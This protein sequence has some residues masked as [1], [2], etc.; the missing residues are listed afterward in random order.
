MSI[1]D[2]A[3]NT[4][5]SVTST[6]GEALETVVDAGCEAVE[7]TV[8]TVGEV[9]EEVVDAAVDATSDNLGEEAGQVAAIAGGVITGGVEVVVTLVGHGSTI[10]QDVAEIGSA[11]LSG[12][13]PGVLAGMLNL[14]VDVVAAAFDFL[15]IPLIVVDAIRDGYQRWQ[16][17]QFVIRLLA[18]R[19]SG[20]DL[21][22]ARA[23]AG[24]DPGPFGFSLEGE[25]RVLLLDSAKTPLYE[26]HNDGTLDLY[27]MAGLLSLDSFEVSQRIRSEVRRVD[28]NGVESVWPVTRFTIAE[29]LDSEGEDCRLRVYA[30]QRNV[31]AEKLRTAR[32][33]AKKLGIR[34][35]WNDDDTYAHF[36]EY[37]SQ[38][39]STKE[40]FQA[41]WDSFSVFLDNHGLRNHTVAEQDT[42]VAMGAFHCPKDSHGHEFNGVCVG[43]DLEDD[44]PLIRRDSDG[45]PIAS[46]VIHRD[47]WV[48]WWSRFIL[49][50]EIGHFLGLRHEGHSPAHI[51]YTNAPDQGTSMIDVTLLDYFL[52]SEPH[53][54]Q[55]DAMNAW[56]FLVD[57]MAECFTE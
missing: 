5:S 55:S 17:R 42:V 50:H 8:E 57:Q 40:D 11:A 13:L 9:V 10:I 26:W 49:I 56:R 53:F 45:D 35:S 36:R 52:E 27:A 54:T 15:R 3:V 22:A 29:Y 28:E 44:T 6:G 30:M 16:L 38:Q 1:W 23:K 18:E 47:R 32:K 24:V 25:H 46:G 20:D 39:I 14:V 33:K 31:I 37:T 21:D 34:L 43:R 19:F 12:D 41:S 4:V 51:M 7:D 2:N 48:T